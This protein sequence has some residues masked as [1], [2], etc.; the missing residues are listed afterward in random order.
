MQL[1]SLPQCANHLSARPEPPEPEQQQGSGRLL[2]HVGLLCMQVNASDP[3]DCSQL[4]QLPGSALDLVLQKLD[5]CSLACTALTC[6]SLSCVVPA[7]ISSIMVCYNSPEEFNSH[8]LWLRLH[9]AGLTSMTQ[10][11][12]YSWPPDDIPYGIE[13]TAHLGR[14]PC[15]RLQQ[16]HLQG[17]CVQLKATGRYPGVLHGC[18]G[19]TAL[20]MQRCFA[21]D[22]AA[23]LAAIAAVIQLHSHSLDNVHD[24]MDKLLFP[25][26]QSLTKLTQLCLVKY[27]Q[28]ATEAELCQPL[29]EL[30]A[31]VDLECLSSADVA[32]GTELAALPTQLSRLTCLHIRPADFSETGAVAEQWRHLSSSLACLTAL[33]DLSVELDCFEDVDEGSAMCGIAQLP[34][35]TRLALDAPGLHFSIGSTCK[36]GTQFAALERLS[37]A[38]C[39]VQPTV[40]AALT[41]LRALALT[42]TGT[43]PRPLVGDSS[44]KDL[45]L[46][47]PQLTGLQLDFHCTRVHCPLTAA[48]E[49]VTALTI[50]TNLCSLQLGFFHETLPHGCVLFAPGTMYP[51]L[52]QLSLQYMCQSHHMQLP[53]SMAISEP[54]AAAAVQLLPCPGE[55]GIRPAAEVIT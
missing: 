11:S 24:E 29:T 12:Q 19:L 4:L 45:L 31:L 36:P 17:L 46:A 37:L 14:L 21:K 9:G 51:C 34:Q 47:V 1:L 41:Q 2:R 5:P 32:F 7:S 48:C 39:D 22:P 40:F 10:I 55:P 42:N 25:G 27:S 23:A 52:R 35:L 6:S 38:H 18:S 15:P 3:Q 13:R 49:A 20:T 16:L 50:S 33:R 53:D 44:P 8:S 54:A 28:T 43:L 30:S 26:A